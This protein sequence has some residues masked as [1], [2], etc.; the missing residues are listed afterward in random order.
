M[1]KFL[2]TNDDGIHS[3]GMFAV[4]RALSKVG[5]VYVVAPSEQQ[6]AMSMALTFRKEVT[7]KEVDFDDVEVAYEIDGSPVDCIKWGLD[8]FGSFVDFDFI[9]SGINMG[10][11]L[12][13]SPY[14][15]G[16]CA[17]AREG[18]LTGI[19]SIALSV[20][21]HQ[22]TE[23]EYITAMIPELLE[24]SQA[25]DPH[26]F[27][28]VNTP[29]M[30]FWQVKGTRI[31]PAADHDYGDTYHFHNTED[32]RYQL[33]IDF[34]EI[35]DSLE[36][37]FNCIKNGYAA[38][39]P[40]TPTLYDSGAI[41]KLKG[42]ST[43]EPICLIVDAQTANREI[44]KKAKR[45]ESNICKWAKCIDRLDM[46]V[47]VTEMYG[48]G[49]TLESITELIARKETI[50]REDYNALNSEDFVSLLDSGNN[51]RIYICGL[52]DHLGVQLTAQG[53]LEHGYNVVVIE[54]CCSAK[55][56]KEHELAMANLRESGCSVIS[57][58]YAL[59]RIMKNAGHPAYKSVSS[60]LSE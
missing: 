28:N 18:A 7:A 19:H 29:N 58:E 55:T 21:S 40:I 16:T 1:Y 50:I 48:K 8:K 3:D 46:P 6:S 24:M 45:W 56:E 22:A 15:S 43:D 11:N 13:S 32:D 14:Y 47:L 54:D 37:D 49:E 36:N 20:E 33:K 17:A 59:M 5:V 26:T 9:I 42:F 39:T 52:E 41:R 23:F 27:L 12:G 2:L 34:S 53:L 44:A 60:I 57:Y 4:A 51:R 10:Y 31:V 30:P 35:D 25:I 38:I